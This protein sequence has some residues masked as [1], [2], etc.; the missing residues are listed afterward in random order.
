MMGQKTGF[1]PAST[2]FQF[3]KD[4]EETMKKLLKITGHSLER[5]CGCSKLYTIPQRPGKV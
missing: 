4:I 5:A 2:E 1:I 3:I